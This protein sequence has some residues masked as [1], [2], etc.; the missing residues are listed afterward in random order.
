MNRK[1]YL[2][3]PQLAELLNK[4]KQEAQASKQNTVNN[5]LDEKNSQPAN[6]TDKLVNRV[7]ETKVSEPERSKK[8]QRL[9]RLFYVIY[10]AKKMKIHLKS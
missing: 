6:K 3:K 10:K 9:Q 1:F 8:Q 7:D 2:T 5:K 4:L